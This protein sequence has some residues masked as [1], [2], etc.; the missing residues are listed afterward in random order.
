MTRVESA[1]VVDAAA[2]LSRIFTAGVG[3]GQLLYENTRQL[4]T[5]VEVLDGSVVVHVCEAG[6]VTALIVITCVPIELLEL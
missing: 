6:L 1:I 2:P 3:A 5:D 4:A